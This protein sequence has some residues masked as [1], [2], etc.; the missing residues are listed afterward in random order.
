MEGVAR[1]DEMPGLDPP[2]RRGDASAEAGDTLTEFDDD[3]SSVLEGPREIPDDVGTFGND[4]DEECSPD[5][6]ECKGETLETARAL[7]GGERPG[8]LFPVDTPLNSDTGI[9]AIGTGLLG[10][11]LDASSGRLGSGFAGIVIPA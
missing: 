9:G 3:D 8:D 11:S 6:D 7:P 1:S 10:R 5:P 4:V 2:A